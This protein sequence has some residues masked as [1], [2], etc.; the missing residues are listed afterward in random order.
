[1]PDETS[2]CPARSH[3][4]QTKHLTYEQALRFNRQ[5]VLPQF[6]L[7][8]QEALLNSNILIIGLGGLGCSAAQSLCLSGVGQL[9]LVDDDSIDSSNLARQILFS[10]SQIGQKKV[11]AARARLQQ[12]NSH[13]DITAVS[14][15]LDDKS[16][17]A[18]VKQ[19]DL[20]LDC[21][22]NLA[23][24]QQI[25]ALCYAA[26][27]PLISGAAIRFEGQLQVIVPRLHTA[28]YA[29]VA[30]VLTAQELSCVEA[31]ILGPV[32]QTIGVQQALL[33]IQYITKLGELPLNQLITYD[34]L[35]FSWQKF[36]INPHP[37]CSVCAQQ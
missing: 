27:I 33:A 17:S 36:T 25:N 32:V 9:T 2:P 3:A 37:K 4:S 26:G 30:P 21:T 19:Q 23:S 14:A 6:D 10:E 35:T 29:C 15:K 22:D 8:G 31:G 16:L 11:D 12:Q 5:I 18:L 13:C 24:R 7:P 28:C 34:A 20:V 1:M